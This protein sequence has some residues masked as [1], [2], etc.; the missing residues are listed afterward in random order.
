MIRVLLLALQFQLLSAAAN[1]TSN[2]RSIFLFKDV[3]KSNTLS[4]T[5]SGFNTFII[6]GVGII[7]NGDIM[8]YSNTPGSKDVL[9]A[10]NGTGI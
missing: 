10:S 7:D 2:I 6:F 1:T 3:L 4:L 8:Y 5:T 9:I